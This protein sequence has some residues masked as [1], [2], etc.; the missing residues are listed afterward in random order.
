MAT[1]CASN[2][3]GQ[4]QDRDRKATKAA[5]FNGASIPPPSPPHGAN[6]PCVMKIRSSESPRTPFAPES[7]IRTLKAWTTVWR[8]SWIRPGMR[9]LAVVF[10]EQLDPTE[11]SGV[12]AQSIGTLN[13]YSVAVAG[14]PLWA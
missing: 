2:S 1:E 3:V 4:E 7:S 14:R 12:E 8:C 6:T 10:A 9:A 13:S 11:G 5:H